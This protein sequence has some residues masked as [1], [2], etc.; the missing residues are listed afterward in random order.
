MMRT[1]VVVLAIALPVT[2]FGQGDP[3]APAPAPAPAEAPAEPSAPTPPPAEAGAPAMP[4]A[5]KAPDETA[6]APSKF[7]GGWRLMLSDLTILR[8]NPTGLETRA[9]VGLQKKLFPS[10]KKITENNFFFVGAYPKLNPASAHFGLG[11]EL[12]PA[13]I[14]NLRV[15]AD[16]Q[17]Y[18]GSF[19]YLQSFTSANANYSDATLA[20]N[21]D[22]PTATTEPQ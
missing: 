7:P 10:D 9:R 18:F 20:D 12:Q 21:K 1:W 2:A 15:M 3:A 13:S 16:I 5:M 17:K 22:M 11:G 4:E 14:F 8:L 6:A 19:G